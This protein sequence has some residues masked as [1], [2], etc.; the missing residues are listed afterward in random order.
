MKSCCLGLRTI[1]LIICV[2]Y[3]LLHGAL[4]ALLIVLMTDPEG[5]LVRMMETIDTND[6]R[7][8]N[9]DFYQ[10]ISRYI[11][12]GHREYFALPITIIVVLIVSNIVAASGSVFSHPLLL[13]PWLALHLLV[14]V[15]MSCLL[16]YSMVLLQDGWLQ[17]II[18]LLVAPLLT[19]ALA[20]W[21]VL[22]RLFLCLKSE[23]RKGK[24]MSSARLPATVYTPEPHNWDTPL[25]IWAMS[26]PRTVWDPV[27]LQ[28]YDPRYGGVGGG[29]RT[30]SQARSTLSSSEHQDTLSLSSKYAGDRISVVSVLSAGEEEEE[31]SRHNMELIP[32]NTKNFDIQ[33]LR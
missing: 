4:L 10:A 29:Q 23:D 7:L 12:E 5:Q 33:G 15:F 11:A 1:S 31:Q 19:L 6:N 18:F 28:H 26:P 27:Y 22:L 2:L 13:L 17:T 21:T 8:E 14:N 20:G 3:L 25:P 32:E 30:P 16:V 24:S 9:S